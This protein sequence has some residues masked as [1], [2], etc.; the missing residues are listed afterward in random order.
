MFERIWW[1]RLARP[2]DRRRSRT[3]FTT[4]VLVF[5]VTVVGG[6]VMSAIVVGHAAMDFDP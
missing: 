5:G 4:D 2:N 3:L 1:I 6:L